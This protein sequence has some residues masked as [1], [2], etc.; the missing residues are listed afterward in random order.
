MCVNVYLNII[1]WFINWFPISH[2]FD[3]IEQSSLVF[4]RTLHEAWNLPLRPCLALP[5]WRGGWA[6]HPSGTSWWPL[7]STPDLCSL[8]G[9]ERAERLLVEAFGVGENSH[10]KPSW[11][12]CKLGEMAGE[13]LLPVCSTWQSLENIHWSATLNCDHQYRQDIIEW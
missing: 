9:S 1:N 12:L 13:D 10:G 5:G 11:D 2:M 7:Q 3:L 8:S 4:S 6:R